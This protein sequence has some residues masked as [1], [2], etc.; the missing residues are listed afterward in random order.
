[1]AGFEV[2]VLV[3]VR[4]RVEHPSLTDHEAA[5]HVAKGRVRMALR[6]LNDTGAIGGFTILNTFVEELEPS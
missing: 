4:T 5:Q 2:D 6:T 1:M 3:S